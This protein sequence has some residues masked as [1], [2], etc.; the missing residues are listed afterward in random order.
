MIHLRAQ[1][2]TLKD[3]ESWL[4]KSIGRLTSY[5]SIETETERHNNFSEWKNSLRE[6][7]E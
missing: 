7:M 1:F 5:T 6:N 3:A 4:T 2:C